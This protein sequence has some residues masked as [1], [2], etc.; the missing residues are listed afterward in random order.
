MAAQEYYNSGYIGG[1]KPD[2]PLSDNSGNRPW[3]PPSSTVTPGPGMSYSPV[4]ENR[5][6]NYGAPPPPTTSY[7]R[8]HN[9]YPSQTSEGMA[10]GFSPQTKPQQYDNEYNNSGPPPYTQ[11]SYG[12]PQ[13]YPPYPTH[14]TYPAHPPTQ[15]P[16]PQDRKDERGFMG[17]VAGGAVGAYAGHQVHHGVL[18]TIGGAIT[19]SVA[20]DAIKKHKKKKKKE[21]K[22]G[23]WG[24]GR[25]SSSS[26]SSSDSD[27]GR[28][29]HQ[30]HPPAAASLRG[31]FSASSTEISLE[32]DY[33]LTARCRSISGEMHRSSISL[34]SVLSNHFGS[35]VWARGGNFGASA[36]NVHLA[37]GGRVLDAE[38]ADGN[39]HWKRAWV[40]LDERITNQNGH[41]VFLD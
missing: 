15:P 3:T 16:Y 24:H 7:E 25:R 36:R 10:L 27:N 6:Y 13:S 8:P 26:S 32:H 2:T 33:E 31:N 34:N 9:V 22:E 28:A 14:D 11:H 12:S 5:P 41:L 4:V 35:F 29:H 39:G 21:K 18:G 23:K 30:Q 19:G 20:E 37:E 40:R 1:Q 38:L 17:A